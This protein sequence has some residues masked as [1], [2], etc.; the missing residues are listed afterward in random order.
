MFWLLIAIL[1]QI[2]LGTAAVFDKL[3]LR[4]RVPDAVTY[5]F[6]L[7]VLGIIALVL[8]PF[9]F[10]SLAPI[11][12]ILALSAGVIFIVSL[13][14]LFFALE[15]GYALSILP[16]VAAL[17]PF[18]TIVFSYVLLGG[19]LTG[20]DFIGILF[21]MLGALFFFLSEKRELRVRLFLFLVSSAVLYAFSSVL[22]KVVF[23][24]ASFITGFFWIK[25]GG[26]MCA[27]ALLAVHSW[28]RKILHVSREAGGSN[29]LWY[30]ANR[31]WA[32]GGSILLSIAIFLS[33]PALVEATQSFR[34]VIIFFAAWFIL[35]ERFRGKT[36]G[37]KITA[38]IFIMLG[39][40]W[41]GVTNYARSIPIDGDRPIEWNMTFSA[42]FSR[43]LGLKPEKNLEAI[44]TDLQPK[45]IRLIAYWDEIEKTPDQF[46]FSS[47]DW[48]LDM[49][50]RY[51]T[52]VILAL[53]MR[54]PRWPECFM[55]GWAHDLSAEQ[56]EE[57]VRG[58][59]TELIKRYRFYAGITIWQLEN[60]PFL[61]FG[62]CPERGKDFFDKERDLVRTLDASRPILVTDSGEFGDWLRAVRRGDIFGTTMYR[63][64][65]PPSIGHVVG[66][67]EYPISPSLFRFKEKLVRFLLGDYT[68]LFVVIEL[69]A[70]PWGKVEIPKLAVGNQLS[71]FS[72]G[73]FRQTIEYAKETGFGEYYFWGAEWWYMMK[74]SGH[75]EY[76]EEVKVL[77]HAN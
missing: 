71:L 38:T 36:L 18:F 50:A 63:K 7:G 3:L 56:R 10:S 15:L 23:E 31:G 51:H 12:I 42:K 11:F 29:R 39:L 53:G 32:A 28:R 40:L 49:A 34:F 64:V 73:Y 75:P 41:I 55:P 13:L 1:A 44:L 62:L 16:L 26:V 9:G 52:Q 60:E 57:A 6:W 43:E 17:I 61:P 27:L 33:H 54:V 4:V 72:L 19:R 20:M 24:H 21:L 69:Q 48:Q 68:K 25:I 70:E 59:I 65:Y 37:I 2:I 30:L 76:W 8:L 22:Q 35:G 67:V 74:H 46:D 14:L 77:M 45:K 47:L 58:Y 66:E 5:T